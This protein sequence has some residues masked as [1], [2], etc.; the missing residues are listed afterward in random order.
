[1]NFLW[2]VR[3]DLL[4]YLVCIGILGAC[5][6]GG[7]FIAKRP[8]LA[9]PL[10]AA[11]V[12]LFLILWIINYGAVVENQSVY[13]AFFSWFKSFSVCVPIAWIAYNNARLSSEEKVSEF[14]KKSFSAILCINIL[15]TIIWTLEKPG[16]HSWLFS[17]TAL[18]VGLAALKINWTVDKGVLGFSDKLFLR[19]YLG[20]LSYLHLFLFP[21][22]SGWLA[23]LV[24]LIP[25]VTSFRS[26]HLW[27]ADR[28]YS[29]WI[30]LNFTYTL[31]LLPYY[32]ALPASLDQVMSFIRQSFLNELT[33]LIAVGLSLHL[34][35]FHLRWARINNSNNQ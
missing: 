31:G 16:L 20:C 28:A 30:F 3:Q 5:A 25:Y 23:W 15:E 18:T 1:M 11:G 35:I 2:S 29:L 13:I 8:R 6:L 32:R 9:F 24:L 12:P 34:A 10:T 22:G 27:F 33:L 4:Y 21:P 19:A 14:V 17:T 7:R 26:P